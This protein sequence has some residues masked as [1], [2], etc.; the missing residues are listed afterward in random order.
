[1]IISPI[2]IKL[3]RKRTADKRISLNL[4]WYRNVHF[5]VSNEVKRQ[6]LDEIREQI[7]QIITVKW[8]VKLRC[9]YYLKRKADV[10]NIHSVVEKFFLDA[11]VELHRLPDDGPSY[12]VGADYE[13]AGFDQ[14]NPRCEIEILEGYVRDR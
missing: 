11:M 8:P 7:Q 6:Y 10:G 5:Q 1:M 2:Y 12:V 3:P 9:K 13:F 4:N 14:K